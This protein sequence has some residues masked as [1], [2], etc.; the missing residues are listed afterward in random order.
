MFSILFSKKIYLFY[1][2]TEKT[3]FL[4]KAS[5]F[6]VCGGRRLR[7]CVHTCM[8]L[9][10]PEVGF[11]HLFRLFSTLFWEKVSY[12][13]GRSRVLANLAGH[14]AASGKHV[15]TWTCCYTRILLARGSEP[16]SL[17]L[18]SNSLGPHP[19]FTSKVPTPCFSLERYRRILKFYL[20]YSQ[21]AF[22]SNTIQRKKES[23]KGSFWCWLDR[24]QFLDF[25]L[26]PPNRAAAAPMGAVIPGSCG[27]TEW[28]RCGD[29][30]RI[31]NLV[32]WPSLLNG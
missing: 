23:V 14:A 11:D 10:R 27:G 26:R 7:M 31:W 2:I 6:D 29:R 21:G 12:W 9:W 30:F 1:N 17:G 13:V 4:L 28:A 15:N 3:N 18:F 19:Q 8:S 32:L 22:D 16:R 25:L 24:L 5:F 20:P